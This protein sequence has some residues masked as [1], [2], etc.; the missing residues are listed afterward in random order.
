[1]GFMTIDAKVTEGGWVFAEF[2]TSAIIMTAGQA[3]EYARKIIAA[4]AELERREAAEKFA[5]AGND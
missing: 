2:G 3:R 5:E 1:M 4:A